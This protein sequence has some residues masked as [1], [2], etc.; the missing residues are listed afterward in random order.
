M[1]TTRTKPVATAA[2][3]R[4]RIANG[5]TSIDV[6]TLAE[7]TRLEQA[8]AEHADLVAESERRAA[9]QAEAAALESERQSVRDDLIAPL[10]DQF[11]SLRA[12]YAKFR[13]A[14]QQLARE[15]AT[16]Q[17]DQDTVWRAAAALQIGNEVASPPLDAQRVLAEA[18]VEIFPEG[19][20]ALHGREVHVE[21]PWLNPLLS[22]ADR[23]EMTAR[24]NAAA[25]AQA[26]AD[27]ELRVQI[28]TDHLAA[29]VGGSSTWAVTERRR[30]LEAFAELGIDEATADRLATQRVKER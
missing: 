25:A 30:A 24:R 20:L 9:E 5:D 16:Y 14:H 11:E 22:D 23:G 17:I 7:A 15:L 28:A 4:E 3:L 29:T 27:H 2:E 12:T 13:S 8:A 26:H 21:A 1:A 18:V 6:A 10:A 19:R